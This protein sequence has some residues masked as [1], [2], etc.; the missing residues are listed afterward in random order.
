MCA[1]SLGNKT[2]CPTFEINNAHWKSNI[3]FGVTGMIATSFLLMAFQNVQQTQNYASRLT[4][5]A[6]H[7]ILAT[8]AMRSV[9]FPTTQN[10][11]TPTSTR[12]L[13]AFQHMSGLIAKHDAKL[14]LGDF[15]TASGSA[16]HALEKVPLA[17]IAAM[18]AAMFGA[19]GIQIW[20]SSSMPRGWYSPHS[21]IS[22]RAMRPLHMSP[23]TAPF[24]VPQPSYHMAAWTALPDAAARHDLRCFAQGTEVVDR[25]AQRMHISRLEMELMAP[26]KVPIPEPI[27]LTDPAEVARAAFTLRTQGVVHLK[28]ILGDKECDEI[29]AEVRH[30]LDLA[31]RDARLG[32]AKSRYDLKMPLEGAGYLAVQRA[33]GKGGLAMLFEEVAT[34][35][36]FL[37][38]LGVLVSE[39]GAIRQ[40]IHPDTVSRGGPEQP[41]YSTFIAMQDVTPEMGPT[42]MIP[43]TNNPRDHTLACGI[44]HDSH[45]RLLAE[46]PNF[47]AELRRGDA[48][49]FD[50]RTLHAGGFNDPDLG[51]RRVLFYVSVQRPVEGESQLPPAPE[52]RTPPCAYSIIRDYHNRFQLKD[53]QRWSVWSNYF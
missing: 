52:R 19:V 33:L 10:L 14:P 13:E 29:L 36:A 53:W 7:P 16:H 26:A 43:G 32:G 28:G 23:H 49:V 12:Q 31:S 44:E 24:A 30:R 39:A 21:P 41:I 45:Q 6:R 47:D 2:K 8:D 27:A 48:V 4:T 17:W 46:R 5:N 20:K 40:P 51:K 38:E 34:E 15:T 22:P 18:L 9:S 25:E 3:I 42:S 37:A 50:S 35:N 1:M 11:A